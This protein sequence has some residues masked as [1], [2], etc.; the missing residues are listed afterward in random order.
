MDKKIRK[1]GKKIEKLEKRISQ[2]FSV[3]AKLV[4]TITFG[5]ALVSILDGLFDRRFIIEP[6]VVP[7]TFEENGITSDLVVWD[8][9]DEFSHVKQRTSWNITGL[10]AINIGYED[11]L[12]D[13]VLFEISLNSIKSL[14]RQVL[15][16]Q[17]RAISGSLY[18]SGPILHLKISITG[19]DSRTVSIDSQSH[20]SIYLAYKALMK[21]ASRNILK[22]IDPYIIA[23]YYWIEDRKEESQAVLK[24]LIASDKNIAGQGYLIWG[25]ML[26]RQKKNNEAIEKFTRAIE[27]NPNAA[28]GYNAM[29]F[30]LKRMGKFEEAIPFF[31]QAI[32]HE[33]T[34]WDPWYLWGDVRFLQGDYREAIRLLEK[35]IEVNALRYESH[36][37][38][39][40][41]FA[42]IGNMDAAVEAILNGIH[43]NPDEGLLYATAA[44]HFWQLNNRMS[45][46]K[47]LARSQELGFD[48]APYVHIEPYKSFLGGKS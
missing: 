24:Q 26:A 43:F 8:L 10:G 16:I 12:E 14:V 5:F 31:K 17:N 20:E 32:N 40:L 37:E 39:S 44:E 33:P 19:F 28:L 41:S 35:A 21:M 6:I 23:K 9:K 42:A 22:T 29:G 27:L 11:I 7:N 46:F 34:L 1:K 2:I 48:M 4:I 38:L 30:M 13:V 15:G 36:N 18:M 3:F 25:E 47:Y 45:A